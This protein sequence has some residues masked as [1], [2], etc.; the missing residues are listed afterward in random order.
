[1]FWGQ[2]NGTVPLYGKGKIMA[3]KKNFWYV[4]VMTN[5]GPVFVTKINYGNRTAEWNK[6]EKPLEMSAERAKDL[7]TGLMMNFN[8]ALPVCSPIAIEMQLY[9]YDKGQFEWKESEGEK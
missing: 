5:Y 7:A 9:Y 2:G 8:T 6:L 3:K 4:L 1:M